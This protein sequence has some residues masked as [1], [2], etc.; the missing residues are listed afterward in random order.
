MQLADELPIF[1][2]GLAGAYVHWSRLNGGNRNPGFR[3]TDPLD[4]ALVVFASLI[5]VVLLM[6]QCCSAA[7]ALFR[8]KLCAL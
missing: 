7:S 2:Y 5:T 6:R 1:W 3:L 8:F 4:L